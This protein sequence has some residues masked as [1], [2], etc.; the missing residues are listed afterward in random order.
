MPIY[1]PK[2]IKTS[3]DDLKTSIYKELHP[4]LHSKSKHAPGED[5][6]PFNNDAKEIEKRIAFY[7]D[8]RHF[9][10]RVI[11]SK[12]DEL[13]KQKMALLSSY[14]K[15]PNRIY[16][17]GEDFIIKERAVLRPKEYPSSH[18]N[19][20]GQAGSNLNITLHSTNT[21]E[22][23]EY[24]PVSSPGMSNFGRRDQASM[25]KLNLSLMMGQA[26]VL[27]CEKSA[28]VLKEPKDKK[29]P[30]KQKS[31][32]TSPRLEEKD[33]EGHNTKR[34]VGINF[35]KLQDFLENKRK[36]TNKSSWMHETPEPY[37]KRKTSYDLTR[38]GSKKQLV[39][40]ETVT[41]PFMKRRIE[42][43]KQY[44]KKLNLSMCISSSKGF[45]EVANPEEK[46]VMRTSFISHDR[47]KHCL[48]NICSDAS[49]KTLLHNRHGLILIDGQIQ[50]NTLLQSRKSKS[51]SNSKSNKITSQSL[52]LIKLPSS[53]QEEEFL[54]S[55]NSQEALPYFKFCRSCNTKNEN[56]IVNKECINGVKID[57]DV[58]PRRKY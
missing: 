48:N 38:S 3:T 42:H 1:F 34:D 44:S 51:M 24:S 39:E 43:M 41:K 23:E 26:N 12:D 14:R 19:V 40:F 58:A 6:D 57:Q 35:L 7:L 37:H 31:N 49:S 17:R 45:K 30:P 46:D 47:N 56:Y 55:K 2:K 28:E 27:M 9:K 13:Y 25:N 29:E 20:Y 5:T 52:N 18:N 11:S 15:L 8:N 21:G 54:Y 33:L 4:D 36:N 16:L 53:T 22:V 32:L 50:N 10:R